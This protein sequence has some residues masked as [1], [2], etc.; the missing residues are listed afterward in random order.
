LFGA[1]PTLA[2]AALY[3]NL[4][5]LSKADPALLRNLSPGLSAY[6]ARLEAARPKR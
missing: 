1:R 3:G 2:D 6:Q 5:M 4:A